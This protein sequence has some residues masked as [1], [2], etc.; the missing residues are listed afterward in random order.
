MAYK[1]P[2][3]AMKKTTFVMLFVA[4]CGLLVTSCSKD[5]VVEPNVILSTTSVSMYYEQTK[6]LAAENATS[7]RSEDDFVAE[8]DGNGLVTGGHVGTTRIV[9]SNGSSSA[10]CNVTILPRYNLYDA[11]ILDWGA[12]MTEI[13]NKET[14]EYSPTSSSATTL[15]YNFTHDTENPCLVM[16][17]FENGKLIFIFVFLK[18]NYFAYAV[19]HLLER[20]HPM[21]LDRVKQTALFGDAYTKDKLK[22]I[23]TINLDELSGS[24][25]VLITYGDAERANSEYESSKLKN[26]VQGNQNSNVL[27]ITNYLKQHTPKALGTPILLPFKA[28]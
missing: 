4:V 9:A 13:R 10:T 15:V 23:L 16:Y 26:S 25:I 19:D 28:K 1:F 22:T 12:S 5:E 17:S 11:P 14:H 18:W 3:T 7:W 21:A 20:F 27:E 6:Q 2:P 8:V 24:P